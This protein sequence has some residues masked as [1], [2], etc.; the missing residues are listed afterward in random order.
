MSK[1]MS[2]SFTVRSRIGNVFSPSISGNLHAAFHSVPSRP[3]VSSSAPKPV[4]T[5][6]NP[7]HVPARSESTDEVLKLNMMNAR[8]KNVLLIHPPVRAV[9]QHILEHMQGKPDQRR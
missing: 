5:S 3:N 6:L 8:V 2:V 1:E 7:L 4:G 9:A